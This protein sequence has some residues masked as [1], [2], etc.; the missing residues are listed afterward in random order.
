M[1]N[2]KRPVLDLGAHEVVHLEVVPELPA[3]FGSYEANVCTG[4]FCPHVFAR[5]KKES[6]HAGSAADED[7]SVHHDEKV[8]DVPPRSSA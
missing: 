3:C 7:L 4:E 6:S 2:R 5:C 1:L 8:C